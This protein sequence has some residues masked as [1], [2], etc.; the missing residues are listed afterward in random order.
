MRRSVTLT[1]VLL[2]T[3]G[4]V[5]ACGSDPAAPAAAG[6]PAGAAAAASTGARPAPSPSSA[7]PAPDLVPLLRTVKGHPSCAVWLNTDP[8]RPGWLIYH[9]GAAI[10]IKGLDALAAGRSVTVGVRHDGQFLST[11]EFSPGNVVKGGAVLY[12]DAPDVSYISTGDDILQ[13]EA[14]PAKDLA[15][16]VI[17]LTIEVDTRNVVHEPFENN[18]ILRVKVRTPPGDKPAL[19]RTSCVS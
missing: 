18:N 14:H 7:P 6:S 15:D 8:G 10:E 19:G 12:P 2:A 11:F 16:K 9:I 17:E 5:A 4:A 1:A 3:L 13:A